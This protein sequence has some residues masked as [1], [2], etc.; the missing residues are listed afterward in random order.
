MRKYALLS[1]VFLALLPFSPST[2]L[3]GQSVY[4]GG[5]ATIPTGDYGDYADPGFM[6]IGGLEFPVGPEGLSVFGEGFFGQ[7]G[8]SDFEG[9]KTQPYG[10]M[11]G[12]LYS[13]SPDADASLYA[14]GQAGI[15][16]HKYSSDDFEGD[17]ESAF[18]YGGGVGYGFPLGGVRGF[19][20]GRYMSASFDDELGGSSSTAFFALFAGV[21]I[22]IGGEG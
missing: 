10:A 17:S 21:S 2:P 16:V 14:F 9:D 15:L 6:V 4:F 7:N 12:L 19:V 8:H 3:A 13:F 22:G 20:E 1:V 11:G 18:G 5:G